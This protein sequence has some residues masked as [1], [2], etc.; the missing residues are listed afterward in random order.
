[1]LVRSTLSLGALTARLQER[2]R[3]KRDK[4]QSAIGS[5]KT[6]QE[7]VLRQQYDS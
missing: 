5:W 4:G 6:E 3:A 2:E 7:M 1:V